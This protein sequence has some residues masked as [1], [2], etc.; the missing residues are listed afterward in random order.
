MDVLLVLN[1]DF[2]LGKNTVVY[3]L[4]IIIIIIIAF[5]LFLNC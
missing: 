4:I 3:R 5:Y 2:F 1:I